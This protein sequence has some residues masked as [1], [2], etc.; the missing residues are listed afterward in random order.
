MTTPTPTMDKTAPANV[1]RSRNA[2][3]NFR[4]MERYSPHLALLRVL[5]GAKQR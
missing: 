5:K 3:R 2:S 1:A 4:Q